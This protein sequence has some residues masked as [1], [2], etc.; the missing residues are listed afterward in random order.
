MDATQKTLA[1]LR[2]EVTG[3]RTDIA[4]AQQ[5]KD[6]HFDR[7]V[8]LTDQ[9]HQSVNELK[10]LKARQ[11]T[12]AEEHAKALDVLR[13]FSLKPV[14]T[15]YRDQPPEVDG[16]VLAVTG[17]GLVEISN[18]ADEGL[19]KGHKLQ[20]YRIGGGRSVYVGRIEVVQTDPDKAVCKIEPKYQK[21]PVQKGD[22]VASKLQ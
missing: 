7:V 11:V 1:A 14:P 5:D 4:Q 17:D 12:L 15:L 9:F 18:G 3:L 6:T 22:R 16:V 19:L 21:S 2:Q 13:L 8:E 20:V 10:R